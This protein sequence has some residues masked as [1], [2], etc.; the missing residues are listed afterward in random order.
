MRVCRHP[1]CPRR[2]DG[3]V[4]GTVL[5]QPGQLG[6]QV[7]LRRRAGI[8]LEPATVEPSAEHHLV[9]TLDLEDG[10]RGE[11]RVVFG[12]AVSVVAHQDQQGQVR[13]DPEVVDGAEVLGDD[14]VLL[15]PVHLRLPMHGEG[16]DVVRPQADPR[17]QSRQRRLRGLSRL[18]LDR[19]QLAPHS[20]L[21]V[22]RLLLS[23]LRKDVPAQVAEPQH[24]DRGHALDLTLSV[25]HD[26]TLASLDL[27]LELVEA[28]LHRR[29]LA[30]TAE[31]GETDRYPKTV[32]HANNQVTV[33]RK[34]H[35]QVR[36]PGGD[37]RLGGRD[38]RVEELAVAPR[39]LVHEGV[40]LQDRHQ[41]LAV[42][43]Q[44][45]AVR[46]RLGRADVDPVRP[47]RS[48]ADPLARIYGHGLGLRH[49]GRRGFLGVGHAAAHDAVG[50]AGRGA[51]QE[52]LVR[53][54]DGAA[55]HG[56][57]A[58]PAPQSDVHVDPQ[59]EETVHA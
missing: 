54:G 5:A 55:V 46:L 52:E 41:G 10:A 34:G 44:Q 32:L 30:T 37:W 42:E 13:R 27:L 16:L 33:V 15:R 14:P 24:Y 18:L 8:V 7:L 28:R 31:R 45:A 4:E 25:E 38:A 39:D 26:A 59:A 19:G 9:V 21:W 3:L 43:G 56:H 2:S 58:D 1:P 12:L 40:V 50:R 36:G 20:E 35:A 47:E 23:K 57:H 22:V 6:G 17:Q 48:L 11:V 53:G 49:R 51:S 29:V